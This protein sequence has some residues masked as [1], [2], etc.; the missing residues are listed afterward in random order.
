MPN[1]VLLRF[2]QESGF[3]YGAVYVN[4]NAPTFVFSINILVCLPMHCP[5][6]LNKFVKCEKLFAGYFIA[7]A[8]N[9]SGM[10]TKM[11]DNAL[12]EA[13]IML[14]AYNFDC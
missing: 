8:L 6:L 12:L 1:P 13:Y 9:A 10:A 4:G 2:L 14:F 3:A 11:L 7:L 5:C